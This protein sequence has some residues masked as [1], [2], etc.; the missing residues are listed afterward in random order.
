MKVVLL[1]SDEFYIRFYFKY[2]E[3]KSNSTNPRQQQTMNAAISSASNRMIE[4]DGEKGDCRKFDD[5]LHKSGRK[6]YSIDFQLILSQ[7]EMMKIYNR[8]MNHRILIHQFQV[9][10]SFLGK[11]NRII[12]L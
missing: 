6:T 4:L 3:N 1:V 10:V 7:N 5:Q 9:R 2:E 11:T 12:I 8:V